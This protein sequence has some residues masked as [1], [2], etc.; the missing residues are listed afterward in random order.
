MFSV[1][2]GSTLTILCRDTWEKCKEPWQQL[3]P[4]CQSR[5]IGTKGSQLRVFKF[6]VVKFSIEDESFELPVVVIDLLP[7]W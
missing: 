2:I 4:W 1:D 5:L 6:A 3:V 7:S